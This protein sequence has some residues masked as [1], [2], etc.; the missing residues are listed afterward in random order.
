MTDEID[1]AYRTLELEPGASLS[2]VEK[3]QREMTTAW[4]PDRF[5]NDSELQ[6][7]AREQTKAIHVAYKVLKR[8]LTSGEMAAA[9]RLGGAEEEPPPKTESAKEPAQSSPADSGRRKDSSRRRRKS[10]R[11]SRGR[12]HRKSRRRKKR[13]TKE[14]LQLALFASCGAVGLTIGALKIGLPIG[15]KTA[16]AVESWDIN[17]TREIG[18][19][20]GELHDLFD[21]AGLVVGGG[22]GWIIGWIVTKRIVRFIA[23]TKRKRHRAA[24][25]AAARQRRRKRNAAANSKSEPT[26]EPNQS[27][28][29]NNQQ[30]QERKVVHSCPVSPRARIRSNRTKGK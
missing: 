9:A 15:T 24:R 18:S 4:S 26:N 11:H 1:N 6:R 28:S 8:H 5:P 2:Q 7:K 20:V 19:F 10:S 23:K 21:I 3:A 22:L 17:P 13:T 14:W 30:N 27:P 29:A 12:K 25:I 16:E